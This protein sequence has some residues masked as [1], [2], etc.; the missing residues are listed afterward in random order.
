MAVR[1]R[2]YGT[3][4]ALGSRAGTG[5]VVWTAWLVVLPLLPAIAPA[6]EACPRCGPLST[7][8][9]PVLPL[10][11][12]RHDD[13]PSVLAAT[14]EPRPLDALQQA[15]VDS[16]AA[17]TRDTAPRMLD[18]AIRAAA[19]DA[20]EAALEWFRRV[21]EAVADAGDDR[22]AVLA[23]LGDSADPAGLLRLKRRLAPLDADVPR[24]IEVMQ[25]AA[26]ARRADPARMARAATALSST[27]AEDRA[28]AVADLATARLD[29]LPALVDLLGTLDPKRRV[30]R[31]LARE[32]VAD[33]GSDARGPLS[34][35]LA[36]PDTSRWQGAI[37]ALEATGSADVAE[38]LL[39]PAL[40][41]GTP[42]GAS[43][44]ALG[45]L[46]RLAADDT[47]IAN[48]EVLA[49]PSQ[50]AAIALVARRLDCV[51]APSGVPAVPADPAEGPATTR[52][53][54]WNPDAHR[55]DAVEVSP[56]LARSIDAAHLAR[57]LEALD[58]RDPL[59]VR[60]VTLARVESLLLAAAS[61]GTAVAP[62]RLAAAFS[63]PDGADP[64][65]VTDVLQ[66]AVHRDMPEVALAAVGRLEAMHSPD[67]G[68]TPAPL[69]PA[70]RTA[71]VKL[72]D[73]PDEDLAF[74][75]A[76]TLALCA[77]DAAYHGS[78][79]VVARLVRTA[80]SR[81][82]DHA[83]VAHPDVAVAN[84]LA[85]SAARYGFRTT[86]VSSGH[87]ALR[88]AA[89]DADTTLVLLAARLARPGAF[90]TLQG[91]RQAGRG[92]VVP[93]MIVVDPLDDVGR[94]RKLT[95]WILQA[96]SHGCVA[97]VDRLESFWRPVL[98]ADGN[99]VR[100]PRFPGELAGIAG[101]D[102]ADPAWRQARSAERLE[103][104][105]QALALLA[106]LG[107]EGH[108]V[109]A[110][111]ETARLALATSALVPEA[112]EALAVVGRPGAQGAI[113]RQALAEADD[114]RR[115]IALA[116]LRTSLGRYGLL[117]EPDEI[118]TLCRGYTGDPDPT[119]RDTARAILA[120]LPRRAPPVI[121]PPVDAASFRPSR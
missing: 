1:V 97:I 47:G 4:V 112:L 39:A 107:R 71:L 89:D 50:G 79:R 61:G 15:V 54:R 78:S 62:E 24:L 12:H 60:L 70:A 118:A 109:A 32:I 100:P 21:V 19:V 108:D 86:V 99:V 9:W 6:G 34:A 27:S 64:G 45:A 26:R 115:G 98:D 103:R 25:E 73:A 80:T 49:P 23:D 10:E 42:P 72:V 59:A 83:V 113:V 111:E 104:A 20:D 17:D 33:I 116:A 3:G 101:P 14:R 38:F 22:D 18:A 96:R 36:S 81:G 31:V 95:H 11:A 94:G 29:A 77:G 119:R 41:P 28:A 105:R 91:L 75:A 65:L 53:W 74:A 43:R 5:R 120:L 58:A 117:L 56:R 110:A 90:E 68:V 46:R 67:A 84:D 40:V 35:I 52:R 92:D 13:A 8:A 114:E 63:G 82:T 93:V 88:A 51:L 66:E 87:E 69:P 102:Q 2:P 37:L 48:P 121:L 85:A 16:L 44:A 55:L 7:P 30:G 57:D 106:L 76:R